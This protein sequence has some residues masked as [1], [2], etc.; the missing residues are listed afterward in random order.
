M[1]HSLGG[2]WEGEDQRLK[3]GRGRGRVLMEIEDKRDGRSI[4]T[5]IPF[6][7]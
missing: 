2:R 6:I 3:E 7:Q 5:L 4:N 1:G